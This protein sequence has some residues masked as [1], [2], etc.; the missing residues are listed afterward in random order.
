MEFKKQDSNPLITL[1][2]FAS[3]ADFCNGFVSCLL[4]PASCLRFIAG[5]LRRVCPSCLDPALHV[6]ALQSAWAEAGRPSVQALAALVL[7]R[8]L[9][10]PS[11]RPDPAAESRYPCLFR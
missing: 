10:P 7:L 3:S 11:F 9:C 1:S 2:G 5:R 4:S 8:E 6:V